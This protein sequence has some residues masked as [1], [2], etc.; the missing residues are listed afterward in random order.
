M[1][2]QPKP[3]STAPYKGVRDFYPK[4]WA[5]MSAIFSHIAKTVKTFGY[6]EYAASPLERAELYE[7]K[8]SQEI[9]RDQ[10]YTFID[11]GE[12]KVTLR[13]EM[14]PTLARMVAGKRRELVFPLRWFSIPNVFRYERPQRGRLREH[15]QLNVDFVGSVSTDD[16]DREI[17]FLAATILSSFGATEKDFVIRIND[18]SLL[19]AA[20]THAD[21]PEEKQKEYLRLLDK[22]DRIPEKEF[23]SAR[24]AI[25]GTDPLTI[26]ET[27]IYADIVEIKKRLQGHKEW[28]SK[29][30][31]PNVEID[32]TI[33][34]GFDYYTGMIFEV[35]DTS[36]ENTRSLFGGGRYDGLVALFGGEPIGAVGFGMGDVGLADF[37][38][39]HNLM[40]QSQSAPTLFL[41]TAPNTSIEEVEKFA[42]VLR[43]NNVNVFVNLSHKSLGDQVHEADKRGIPYFVAIGA[44]EIRTQTLKA[45]R[46]I[47]GV[48]KTAHVNEIHSFFEQS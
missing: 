1:Q 3:L 32:P 17:L 9:V 42:H 46:L 15:Y 37:L 4:D 21:M 23:I 11:R 48:E 27:G 33:T 44:D 5:R 20:C 41:G 13:P 40:P 38:E 45:K 30:G 47:D 25:T 39:T 18:R 34:R 35:F 8:T 19:K 31:V 43:K 28:L 29:C 22:K 12:R 24:K 2:P 7:S 36:S 16:S 10:T 14:T 6:E 26:L